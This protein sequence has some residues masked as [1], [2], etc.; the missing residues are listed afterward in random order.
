[1]PNSHCPTRRDKNCRVASRGVAS[2]AVNWELVPRDRVSPV[3]RRKLGR[4]VLVPVLPTSQSILKSF[5]STRSSSQYSRV[6]TVEWRGLSFSI[7]SPNAVPIPSV[8]SVT[9]SCATAPAL[10]HTRR[11]RKHDVIKVCSIEYL[12]TE[13]ELVLPT[14]KS[15][16][17][18]KNI[19]YLAL[20]LLSS[21]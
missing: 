18:Q 13:T 7:D 15:W 8:H 6:T 21:L 1:M 9:E 3:D 4:A 17:V 5:C 19:E 10:A 20:G 11:R 16:T 12:T 14:F 2:S